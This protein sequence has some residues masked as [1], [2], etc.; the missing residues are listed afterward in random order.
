MKN[1]LFRMM[2]VATLI[3]ILTGCASKHEDQHN[4]IE[5][6]A[7]TFGEYA[8]QGNMEEIRKVCPEAAQWNGVSLNYNADNIEIFPEGENVY[9]IK[10]GPDASI[11]VREGLNNAMEVIE[12]MG[13]FNGGELNGDNDSPATE[14]YSTSASS[15]DISAF[16]KKL[17]KN[18][19]TGDWQDG[20][21]H[22]AD[23]YGDCYMNVRN[24]NS[25]AIDGSDYYITF[26]YEYLYGDMYDPQ[27]ITK[28]GKNIN[29]GGA[30]KFTY[31]YSDDCSPTEV[32]VKF[33]LSDR[34]L[35]DKYHGR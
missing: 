11:K 18:V 15:E 13:I 1:Y 8:K 34:E 32:S 33:R 9:T 14:T 22:D 25:F 12:T 20:G 5:E 35:Y 21:W 6:F 23:N 16:A 28:D 4:G 29:A 7:E 26:K 24:K 2:A 27:R 19:T 30:A 10:Y 3:F 17:K 31:T